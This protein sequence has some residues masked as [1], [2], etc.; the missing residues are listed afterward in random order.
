[1][2]PPP[3]SRGDASAEKRTLRELWQEK[4]DLPPF[5]S[6][7]ILIV[8]QSTPPVAT[9]C[10]NTDSQGMTSHLEAFSS[11]TQDS[12]HPTLLNEDPS[13]NDPRCNQHIIAIQTINESLSHSVNSK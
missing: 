2:L 12:G 8:P 9:M 13:A 6:D 5:Q 3:P 10:E 7:A 11:I 4:G 1:V